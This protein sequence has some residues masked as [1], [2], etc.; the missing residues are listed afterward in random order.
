MPRNGRVKRTITDEER[1]NPDRPPYPPDEGWQWRWFP[2]RPG[3]WAARGSPG[4][5]NRLA[6]TPT[7]MHVRGLGR[8]IALLF[9]WIRRWDYPGQSR[10]VVLVTGKEEDASRVGEWRRGRGNASI[11]TRDAL[12]TFAEERGRALLEAAAELRAM[13]RKKRGAPGMVP[14]RIRAERLAREERERDR[15][16]NGPIAKPNEPPERV[17]TGCLAF[18]EEALGRKLD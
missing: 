15:A 9:P 10:C 8:V 2:P 7:A 18:V 3:R 12:A 4:R 16:L 6:L 5:V 14:H 13:P 1:C 17:A 11:E